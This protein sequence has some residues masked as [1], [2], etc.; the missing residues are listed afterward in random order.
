MAPLRTDH[1]FHHKNIDYSLLELNLC[2]SE[3]FITGKETEF[4]RKEEKSKKTSDKLATLNIENKT[5]NISMM[6]SR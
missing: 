3:S 6:K 2:C 5:Q 1:L 4:E